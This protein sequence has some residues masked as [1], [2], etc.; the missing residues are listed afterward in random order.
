MSAAKKLHHN[1]KAQGAVFLLIAVLLL[2]TIVL[3]NTLSKPKISAQ[4]AAELAQLQIPDKAK[5]VKVF[6][7][8]CIEQMM[9][10][11]IET[12]ALQG[13]YLYLPQSTLTTQYATVA[14]WYNSDATNPVTIPSTLDM[15]N[16]LKQYAEEAIP[17]C[18]QNLSVFK[19]QWDSITTGTLSARVTIANET[20]LFDFGYPIGLT[21]R[22]GQ[23]RLENFTL[24]VPTRLGLL[25]NTLEKE[26]LQF[27]EQVPFIDLTSLSQQKTNAQVLPIDKG[28]FLLMITDNSTIV[29]TRQLQFFAAVSFTPNKSPTIIGPG[30]FE[31]PEEQEME[32]NWS[33]EDEDPDSVTFTDDTILFDI[34]TKGSVKFI[35][36]V[37]GTFE[38]EITATDRQGKFDKKK[39]T[40]VV[41]A[42]R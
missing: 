9:L 40:F 6:V 29:K 3:I 31:V 5:P 20:V 39:V 4:K 14:Y 24:Q 11:G 23:Y 17:Q 25:H 27:A 36:H 10:P 21:D 35:A 33:A 30:K 41:D 1:R 15:E 7:D 16:Q 13:G 18:L 22:N 8:R 19:K 34:S 42:N 38:V 37:P 12:L 28:H 32:G 2:L 26:I